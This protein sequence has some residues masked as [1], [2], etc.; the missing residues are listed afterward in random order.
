G[1]GEPRRVAGRLE[2][3]D[4]DLV[5]ADVVGVRAAAL[6]VVRREHVRLEAADQAH[7]P[8]GGLLQ[9]H[10]RETA[11]GQRWRRVALGPAGVDEAETD[12][13]EAEGVAGGAIFLARTSRR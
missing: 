8:L 11:L 13:A 6:L 9:R 4:A 3:G 5:A 7:Q 10:Q 12:L 1:V 2:R